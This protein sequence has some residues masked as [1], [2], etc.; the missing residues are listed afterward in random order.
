MVFG[1]INAVHIGID[2]AVGA[3]TIAEKHTL[4]SLAIF[5]TVSTGDSI[6]TVLALDGYELPK[7]LVGCIHITAI[8]QP[9]LTL[10]VLQVGINLE[11][12]EGLT[13]FRIFRAADECHFY[14]GE[15]HEGMCTPVTAT[16]KEALQSHIINI[17]VTIGGRSTL[18]DVGMFVGNFLTAFHTQLVECV[19][20]LVGSI[21]MFQH[22]LCIVDIGSI[23]ASLLSKRNGGSKEL[24][25]LL[26]ATHVVQRITHGFNGLVEGLE[27]GLVSGS[28]CSIEGIDIEVG[29]DTAE[30][31]SLSHYVSIVLGCS[32]GIAQ[33][34]R[35]SSN[36]RGV[37]AVEGSLCLADGIG[38]HGYG[39][40]VISGSLVKGSLQVGFHLGEVNLIA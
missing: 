6:D 30:G 25:R 36:G 13:L 39:Q 28:L 1:V 29:L 38:Q 15:A 22:S 7:I 14:A 37:G 27:V 3:R 11:A 34:H 10:A 23:D 35:S 32:Q 19:V 2:I 17:E 26:N 24:Q 9:V 21:G 18:E 20:N 12:A 8:V 16:A 40:A 31:F 4:A 5:L 33:F